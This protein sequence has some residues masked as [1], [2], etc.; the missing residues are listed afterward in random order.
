M[1]DD[2]L[3]QDQK[4]QDQNFIENNEILD[5]DFSDLSMYEILGIDKFANDD[6]IKK[7]YRYLVLK[8]HPD[9]NKDKNTTEKFIKI[10]SAYEI[11]IN[12]N[13]REEYDIMQNKDR[14]KFHKNLF[15]Y[16][17]RDVNKIK[18][19]INS[20]LMLFC[21]D[22]KYLHNIEINKYDEALNYL[23]CK[24]IK[25][26]NKNKLDIID[27]VECELIDRYN[28]N[29]LFIEIMR[30]SRNNIKLY[31]PLRNDTNIFYNEGE[32]DTDGKFGDLILHT[33]TINNCGYY[34]KNGDMFKE[35][36]N[37]NDNDKN[38]T[39]SYYH[40]DGKIININKN[41]F[42]DDKYIIFNGFGLPRPELLSG[43]G[44]L[45]CEIKYI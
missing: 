21:K 13:L 33:K 29:Y 19:H 32:V 3:Q 5:P 14:N 2:N 18:E 34:C 4:N 16:F 36:I 27:F 37:D 44:D 20:F 12:K 17:S 31:V 7:A 40:I 24:Y 45:I 6:E 11:L 26:E 35:I 1:K 42:I 39:I 28:D 22:K 10:H 38:E 23:I 41:D 8:Y 9:K 25:K 15:E 30:K 43:R